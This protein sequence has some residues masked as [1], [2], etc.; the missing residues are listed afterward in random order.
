MSKF[1]SDKIELPHEFERVLAKAK[2]DCEIQ[3]VVMK[4]HIEALDI[5]PEAIQFLL[6]MIEILVYKETRYV[7]TETYIKGETENMKSLYQEMQ[8][9]MA[10]RLGIFMTFMNPDLEPIEDEIALQL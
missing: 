7:Q 3:R 8:K 2:K 6:G 10:N 5:T 9:S 4:K 1:P